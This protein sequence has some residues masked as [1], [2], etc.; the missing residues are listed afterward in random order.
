MLVRAPSNGRQSW[1]GMS[2]GIG[3]QLA[4]Y[5]LEDEV[6]RGGMGVVYRA[7]ELGL[8]RP[9][10]LKLIAPELAGDAAFRE[11]FLRES[12]LAA[13]IDHPGILPVYAAGEADGE[14]YLATR[15]VAGTD[16]RATLEEDGPL[17]P[18]RALPLVEQVADALDAAHERGLVHRDVKPAN[19]L[20]DE[21]GHCYLADFGLSRRLAEQP[22][23]LGRL[24]PFARDGRLRRAR[25]DPR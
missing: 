9:V 24:R 25:A 4:G 12:R 23:S 8:D 15:Y 20:V 13:S 3:S 14:V 1:S 17:T 2:I 16:L 22:T 7:T 5:R 19:V 6:G 11:R 21:R 18:E 10:A